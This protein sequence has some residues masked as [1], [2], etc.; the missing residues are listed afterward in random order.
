MSTVE[1]MCKKCRSKK[2]KLLWQ[3]GADR[4]CQVC[5]D[6]TVENTEVDIASIRR[7]SDEERFFEFP[8]VRKSRTSINPGGAVAAVRG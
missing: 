3:I 8:F 4:Y 6:W 5:F 7:L 2:R 1:P